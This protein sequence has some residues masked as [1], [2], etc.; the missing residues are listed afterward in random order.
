MGRSSPHGSNQIC[1]MKWATSVSTG[2]FK[3]RR[4]PRCTKKIILNMLSQVYMM[5]VYMQTSQKQN[6]QNMGS[7]RG[8]YAN[9]KW[10]GEMVCSKDNEQEPV[11]CLGGEVEAR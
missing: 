9:P 8:S 10:H 5:S 2:F 11:E 4:K 6:H 1:A 7:I 3:S